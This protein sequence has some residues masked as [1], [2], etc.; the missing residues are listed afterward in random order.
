MKHRAATFL[1]VAVTVSSVLAA[2]PH[3]SYRFGYSTFRED[4]GRVTVLADGF[5]ASMAPKTG[6]I[7]L[8]IAVAL[9]KPGRTV[10]FRPESFTLIDADG[11][12]VPAAGFEEVNSKYG[13]QTYDRSLVR[14]R[15]IAVPETI[16]GLHEVASRFYPPPTGGTRI[17][18]VELAT[19]T[20]F[21]DVLYFPVPPSGLHGVLTLRV[22]I[23]GGSPV[24]VRF[25]ANAKDLSES[26]G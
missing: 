6:Y 5:P 3:T 22:E 15:P 17:P 20:W 19:S 25:V 9:T 12:A 7:P 23:P 1:T 26:A 24:E 16:S 2:I 14:V 8:P 4:A 13:R 18:E 11:H 10:T 21:R